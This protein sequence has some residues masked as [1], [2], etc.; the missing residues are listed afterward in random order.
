MMPK[1]RIR[2]WAAYAGS[3]YGSEITLH[4]SVQAAYLACCATFGIGMDDRVKE[5]RA[6]HWS[7][8]AI[9]AQ[10][11]ARLDG[12]C[13]ARADDWHVNEVNLS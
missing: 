9:D 5:W 10:L 12:H 3:A 13:S 2:W 7:D 6:Q 4:R 11:V 1:T 8:D